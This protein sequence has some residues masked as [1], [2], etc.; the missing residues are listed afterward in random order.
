ML[1]L[2]WRQGQTDG[3]CAP[4]SHWTG[5]VEPELRGGRPVMQCG[6]RGDISQ[7][8][9]ETVRAVLAH[10][11]SFLNL[12]V[13]FPDYVQRHTRSRFVYCVGF[14]NREGLRVNSAWMI[15]DKATLNPDKRAIYRTGEHRN[16]LLPRLRPSWC[17][18]HNNRHCL[19]K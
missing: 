19:P 15:A 10:Q 14:I 4:N 17:P 18:A 5:A 11:T 2:V 9:L 7:R 8:G 6:A 1:S 3:I 12:T 13:L 16:W